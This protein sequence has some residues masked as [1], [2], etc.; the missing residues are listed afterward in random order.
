MV[1]AIVAAKGDVNESVKP[2]PQCD[3]WKG[4]LEGLLGG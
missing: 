3:V 2:V 1:S 4:T